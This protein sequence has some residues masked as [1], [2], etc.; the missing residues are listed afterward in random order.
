[1][2]EYRRGTGADALPY[3]QAT[4]LNGATPRGV[5]SYLGIT[6]PQDEAEGVNLGTPDESFLFSTTDRQD[7]PITAGAPFGPGPF[8]PTI[9]HES[10]SAFKQRI[11][12]ALSSVRGNVPGLE[13]YLKLIERGL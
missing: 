4:A 3:G 9:R 12:G 8:S 7:E 6:A 10:E 11:A 13:K 2:P 5:P 1:M